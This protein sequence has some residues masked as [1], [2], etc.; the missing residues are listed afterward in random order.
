MTTNLCPCADLDWSGHDMTAEHHPECKWFTV[1]I[2]YDR[3]EVRAVEIDAPIILPLELADPLEYWRFGES[4]AVPFDGTKDYVDLANDRLVA[5]EPVRMPGA[6]EQGIV[7][8]Y[9]VP[10]WYRDYFLARELRISPMEITDEIRREFP[11]VYTDD[12]AAP[13]DGRRYWLKGKPE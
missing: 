2:P 11:L 6:N 5:C 1:K 12:G 7:G 9:Q 8:Y 13:W 10:E 4:G 3:V